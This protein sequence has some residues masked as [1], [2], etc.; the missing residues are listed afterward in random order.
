MNDA[1]HVALIK[2]AVQGPGGAWADLG[3]GS[4]AF[5]LALAELLG[6]EARIYS[7]D[8]NASALLIQEQE[9]EARFPRLEVQLI[10]ADLRDT[11]DIPSALDGIVMANS[12]HFLKDACAVLIHVSGWL[13]P[14]GKIV[15]VE[16]DVETRNQ[17]VPYPMPF[18][19]LPAA[20]ACAGLSA[21]RLLDS[22][23]SRYHGR[24]YSAVCE[25][26]AP[27]RAR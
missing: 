27:V 7:V 4:G 11:L 16:Y 9:L 25:K 21:P 18:S 15:I 23:P 14:G 26:P 20:A 8:S 12:L 22:R 2:G 17:W 5:T 13:K 1:D 24:V 6:P 3:S 10:R 19:R